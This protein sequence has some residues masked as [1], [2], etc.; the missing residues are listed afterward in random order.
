MAQHKSALKRA[1]ASEIRRKR[2]KASLSKAK[3]LIKK[4]YSTKDKQ[5]A[6]I[7][8]KEAVSFLDKTVSKGRLHKNNAARKKAA[9]TKYVN[10]LSATKEA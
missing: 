3:T 5:Q 9:L 10:T 1:R 7:A 4:V 6:E 2:N 8:L